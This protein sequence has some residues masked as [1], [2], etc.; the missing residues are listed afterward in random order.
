MN[1]LLESSV[2]ETPVKT[3]SYQDNDVEVNQIGYDEK[4][5]GLVIEEEIKSDN[6]RNNEKLDLEGRLQQDRF[7]IDYETVLGQGHWGIVNP[8]YDNLTREKVVVKRFSPSQIALMQMVKANLDRTAVMIND[9]RR[10]A[11]CS[12]IVPSEIHIDEKGEPYLVMPEYRTFLSDVIDRYLPYERKIEI[13]KG[14]AK[15][16]RETHVKL[17][18]I[19]LDQKPE[20]IALD[21]QDLRPLL[22][23]F[24]A[25]ACADLSQRSNPED[26]RG[27]NHTRAPE[28]YKEGAK[29]RASANSFSFFSLAYRL[30]SKEGR[31]PFE[32]ELKSDPDYVKNLDPDAGN[33][34]LKN[35]LRSFPKEW[36]RFL[37][38]C[39]NFHP[40][41]RPSNGSFLVN[42]L[43]KTLDSMNAKKIIKKA[44]SKWTKILIPGAL[45]SMILYG[46][47]YTPRNVNV[48]LRPKFQGQLYLEGI[49]QGNP[50]IFVQED[51]K[52]LPSPVLGGIGIDGFA[53][54]IGRYT[55]DDR[56]VAFLVSTFDEAVKSGKW[57]TWT[58][59][60]LEKYDSP[61]NA[62]YYSLAQFESWMRNKKEVSKTVYMG[63]IHHRIV[64]RSIEAALSA[65]TNLEGA[66]DLEDV[67]AISYLG[68]E[69]VEKAKEVSGSEDFSKYINAE[70]D[71]SK[72]ISENEKQFL[73]QWRVQIDYNNN[74]RNYT[75]N[76][77]PREDPWKR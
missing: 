52:D 49:T 55:S 74:P 12:Y 14:L 21:N 62:G 38:R 20:N 31:Y 16:I 72:V 2:G 54:N 17:R 60:D 44:I 33:R 48:A 53:R 27:F 59:S 10:R 63:E 25:A 69:K 32:E 19:H 67:L 77:T 68:L 61:Y 7:K 5:K 4:Q 6:L 26:N 46:S 43:D 64:A 50:K 36:R 47:L 73:L 22:N 9:A 11:A 3:F 1:D 35:K 51:I 30:L 70:T 65:A 13:L 28:M 40:E 24:G 57:S 66:I 75:N 37:M 71:G 15:G 18:T 39:G 56:S 58:R 34:I 76:L 8:A 23:D 42:E 41:K 45:A 29:A